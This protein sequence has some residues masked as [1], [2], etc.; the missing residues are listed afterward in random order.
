MEKISATTKNTSEILAEKDAKIAELEALVK[1]YEEQLRLASHR[2]FGTSSEKGE[3]PEQLGLFDE[4][5]NTADTNV[6]E[7]D[8]EE[9]TYKRRKRVGKREEDLSGLPVETIEYSLPESE[10][11][12]L[13]LWQRSAFCAP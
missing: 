5:E 3:L 4:A 1:Y 8:I 6:T 2:Q 9:I 7:P 12:L 13:G 11:A 10:Q